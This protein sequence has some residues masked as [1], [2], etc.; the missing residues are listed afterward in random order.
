MKLVR[1]PGGAERLGD[2]P[3]ARRLASVG[4]AEDDGATPA[5]LDRR[6]GDERHADA[7]EGDHERREAERAGEDLLVLDAVLEREDDRLGAD[8]RTQYG[9]CRGRVVRLDADEHEVG[10]R[11]VRGVA[12]G[13]HGWQVEGALGE[14]HGEAVAPERFEVLAARHEGHVVAALGEARAEI[15]TDGAGSQDE[16]PHQSPTVS[17]WTSQ[18]SG[19]GGRS[20]VWPPKHSKLGRCRRR[21][22]SK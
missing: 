22:S 3:C 8:D 5:V 15:A 6:W 21:S 9:G 1:D 7:S 16:D 14:P 17:Q 20:S 11:S 12:D 10:P 19:T 2:A 4:L 13:V 18:N